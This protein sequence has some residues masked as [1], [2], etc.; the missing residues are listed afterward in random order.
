MV[1]GTVGV[2]HEILF[3]FLFSSDT[4]AVFRIISQKYL[5]FGWEKQVDHTSKAPQLNDANGKPLDLREVVWFPMRFGNTLSKIKF[6][7]EGTLAVDSI[8]GTAFI[9]KHIDAILFR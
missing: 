3:G 9:N 5:G 1:D 4:G 2:Y 6:L 8:V 7:V